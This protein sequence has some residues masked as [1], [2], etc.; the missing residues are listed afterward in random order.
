MGAQATL[1]TPLRVV[2]DTNVVLS[3]LMFPAGR[4]AWLRA[5][6][7]SRRLVVLVSRATVLEL[8]RVLA[9][10]KFRLSTVEREELLADYLP[11]AE[12]VVIASPAP[13]VPACR[14]PQDVKFLVLAKSGRA[15]ALLT[16]DADL[17]VLAPQFDVPIMT[18]EELR[19]AIR[20]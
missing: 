17:L 20:E 5:T 12:T 3:A 15:N 2:L 18:A 8:M 10:P 16:G 9:Y 1:E 7:Q 4:V 13:P 6:W 11:Y 14:D 19:N